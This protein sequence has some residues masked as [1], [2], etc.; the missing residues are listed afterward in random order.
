MYDR[1]S[2]AGCD[3]AAFTVCTVCYTSVAQCQGRQVRR[4]SG[5]E[6][7]HPVFSL[8]SRETE[9]CSLFI[10][11]RMKLEL[12]ASA[13][14]SDKWFFRNIRNQRVDFNFFLRRN[15]S[16]RNKKKRFRFNL[17]ISSI[18]RFQ[19]YSIKVNLTKHIYATLPCRFY[20]KPNS[21]KPK[22]PRLYFQMEVVVPP[23]SSP[24]LP[25]NVAIFNLMPKHN[26]QVW[27]EDEVTVALNKSYFPLIKKSHQLTSSIRRSTKHSL[28]YVV[29]VILSSAWIWGIFCL[30]SLLYS[31][32]VRFA[33]AEPTGWLNFMWP[34]FAWKRL[35]RQEE[36]LIDWT[37]INQNLHAGMQQDK[38]IPSVCHLWQMTTIYDWCPQQT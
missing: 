24:S 22:L 30:S 25:L 19:I 11:I 1:P 15:P 7:R 14:D 20:F 5:L 13:I 10:F 12:S 3:D 32:V 37:S 18:L 23:K 38:D 33:A 17:G 27:Q 4:D 8:Y 34:W 31:A 2:L 28:Q 9:E 29:S 21:F 6:R 36:K 16:R 35:V 26:L